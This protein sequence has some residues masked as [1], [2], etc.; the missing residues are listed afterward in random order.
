MKNSE[1]Y[2]TVKLSKN[3]NWKY[4]WEDLD[5][6][7]KWSVSEECPE[8]YTVGVKKQGKTFVITNTGI[9]VEE[10]ELPQTGMLWWPV[11]AG[12]SL[13]LVFVIIGLV[14]RKRT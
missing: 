12:L 4:T 11:F 14:L 6:S 1:I 13:G 7:F 3:N 5:E 10:P 9:P 8:G 2:D